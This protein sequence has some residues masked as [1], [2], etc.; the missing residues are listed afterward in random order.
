M[1]EHAESNMVEDDYEE[2]RQR[3][4]HYMESDDEV[5]EENPND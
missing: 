1:P 2:Y 4:R 5:M 3:V